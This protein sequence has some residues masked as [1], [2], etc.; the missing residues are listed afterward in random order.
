MLFYSA[1]LI[2]NSG[3]RFS[4]MLM[5][6]ILILAGMDLNKQVSFAL[7]IFYAFYFMFLSLFTSFSAQPW[8]LLKISRSVL[9]PCMFTPTKPQPSAMTVER[10]SGGLCDRDLNVKVSAA[11]H[12]ESP[13]N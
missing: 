10:C 12:R 2:L 8:P 6:N 9:M 1:I 7:N 11:N 4:I 3:L 13:D 5:L